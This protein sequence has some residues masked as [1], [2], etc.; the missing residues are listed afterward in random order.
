MAPRAWLYKL[1]LPHWTR[2][3]SPD[4]NHPHKRR[5]THV[6]RRKQGIVKNLWIASGL[7]MIF[8]ATPAMVMAL[9]LGTTFLSFVILDETP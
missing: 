3:R 5:F 9:T 1:I 7:A 2:D 4:Q 8:L 6:Y